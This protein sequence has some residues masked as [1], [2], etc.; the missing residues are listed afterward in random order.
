[1]IPGAGFSRDF[2]ALLGLRQ[3]YATML[4]SSGQVDLFTLQ[5]LLTHKSPEMTLR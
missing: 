4:A 5:K 2:R 3:V 1:M